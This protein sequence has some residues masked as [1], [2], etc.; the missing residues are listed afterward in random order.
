MGGGG[1]DRA[2]V[3]GYSVLGRPTNLDVS[4]AR[5]YSRCA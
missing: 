2:F 1:V 5:A 4:R 3:L